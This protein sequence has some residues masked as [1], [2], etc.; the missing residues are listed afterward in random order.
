MTD[1]L[2]A[3]AGI[4]GAPATETLFLNLLFQALLRAPCRTP[5]SLKHPHI[6]F[7]LGWITVLHV[8][9]SVLRST[10]QSLH[11]EPEKLTHMTK[12]WRLADHCD[13]G[14]IRQAWGLGE[15][16]VGGK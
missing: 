6:P 4:V 5:G 2:R 7:R 13:R 3:F 8:A 12:N 1:G 11:L 9:S 15:A 14:S 10:L 16:I